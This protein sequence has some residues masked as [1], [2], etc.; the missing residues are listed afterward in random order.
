MPK[1][2]NVDKTSLTDKGILIRLDSDEPE[3][4]FDLRNENLRDVSIGFITKRSPYYL[5]RTHEE[6]KGTLTLTWRYGKQV[7][8]EL[9]KFK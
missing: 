8:K 2:K 4:L 3:I 5:D 1:K 9:E 7:K 6:R